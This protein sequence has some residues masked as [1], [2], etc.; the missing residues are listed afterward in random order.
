MQD[1][2][3]SKSPTDAKKIVG[4]L[5][6]EKRLRVVAAIALGAKTLSEV[7]DKAGL[8]DGVAT[9]SLGQ[10][11]AAGLVERESAAAYRLKI[12]AFR[13]AARGDSG[14]E[15]DPGTLRGVLR[16]GRLP[17]SRSERQAVLFQ[18]ADL[19][20]PG[21]RYPEAEVNSK[22]RAVHPD[23]ALLRRYLVD[24]RLLERASEAAPE[25]HSVVFYW[26]IDVISPPDQGIV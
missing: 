18:L 14:P 16:N 21:R 26:R 12:E 4:L 15:S 7:C 22:L 25:G 10:L 8:E 6:D 3:E 20:E 5:A 9:K 2:A 23:Y 19:F 11:F 13:E 1:N 17:R 24:E